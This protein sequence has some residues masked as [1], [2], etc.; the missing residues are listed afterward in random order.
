MSAS[1]ITASAVG[2]GTDLVLLHSLL[3][4]RGVWD[5]VVPA[6]A[7]ERRVWVVDLPGYGDS[8][9]APADI[10]AYADRI[11]E[12]FDDRGLP[13]DT[14]VMGNGLGAAV[15]LALAVRHGDRFDRLV[16][17][18]GAAE[19]PDEAKQPFVTMGERVR[20]E[21]MAGIVD[22]AVRRIFTDDYLAAHPD[23]V[24]ERREV[25]LRADPEA[26]A[27]ACDALRDM[28][29]RDELS[30]ISNPTLVV[31]GDADQAT[32][33][34]RARELAEG[35]PDAQLVVLPD[36]AH[37]PQLQHPDEFLAAIAPFLDLA[38]AAAP[39]TA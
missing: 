27:G 21:G 1:T 13:A 18:G 15:A 20:A 25:L 32:P 5:L 29:L 38:S 7:R 17:A 26:F 24:E 28:D 31:V 19:F 4:D 9:P 11:A 12:F 35:I 37:A 23:A 6:L 36:C 2:E 39:T 14:A 3:T 22:L 33:P 16:I 34:A 30:G 8:A 10:G